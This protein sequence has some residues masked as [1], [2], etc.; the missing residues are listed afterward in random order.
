MRYL[1]GLWDTYDPGWDRVDPILW[2]V[3]EQFSAIICG[4]LP[5]C[6]AIVLAMT[7]KLRGRF[8]GPSDGIITSILRSRPGVFRLAPHE[9]K[10]GGFFNARRV[11]EL[12]EH[13][14]RVAHGSEPGLPVADER[15]TAARGAPRDPYA[16]LYDLD[17]ETM[18]C[19]GGETCDGATCPCALSPALC[20]T[21][22]RRTSLGARPDDPDM[23]A[24]Q[25]RS[26]GD[27]VRLAKRGSSAIRPASMVTMTVP[28]PPSIAGG[29]EFFDEEKLGGL[30]PSPG[31]PL[32]SAPQERMS[33][34]ARP[35]D[36]YMV[37][38]K[39]RSPMEVV[40]LSRRV[41]L[42]RPCSL[43]P[44]MS[45]IGRAVSCD[46]WS[47]RE[48]AR[49]E[50]GGSC[51]PP[52]AVPDENRL[53]RVYTSSPDEAEVDEKQPQTPPIS[54]MAE[55]PPVADA[56]AGTVSRISSATDGSA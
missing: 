53:T 12:A 56:A 20:R 47:M 44:T 50:N 3:M 36:P 15:K 54:P 18:D 14:F 24:F 48:R 25:I 10:G 21:S 26:P 43:A 45:S 42:I 4:S 37:R 49:E 52:P 29:D 2:S 55:T 41:P 31:W 19:G 33:R 8:L 32:V 6:R 22:T 51:T 28:V 11:A 34:A 17:E 39:I 13:Q 9:K 27:V 30:S 5:S 16:D 1:I 38:H 35:G 7:P 40:E 46:T 23:V